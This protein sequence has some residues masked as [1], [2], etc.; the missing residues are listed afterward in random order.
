MLGHQVYW[1]GSIPC[2]KKAKSFVSQVA[3]GAS[4]CVSG[5]CSLW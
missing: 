2:G 4:A 3:H 1:E 5:F